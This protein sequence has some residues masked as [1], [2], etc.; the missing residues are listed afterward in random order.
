MRKVKLS[1]VLF[2]QEGPGVRN[3]QFTDSG[4][5]LLN[6]G[7]INN[8]EID[9]STTKIHISRDEAYGKYKHFLAE[10]GDLVIASSGIIVSNFHNKIAF[11]KK[12]HLPLCMNTSTIRFRALDDKELDINFF[13]FFLQTIFFKKQL[14]RLITGSAQLNFGPSHLKQIELPLPDIRI[15]KDIA[16]Q[17]N[18]AEGLYRTD[19]QLSIKYLEL[20]QSTYSYFFGDVKINR[21][22]YG[23][24][25]MCDIAEVAS[26]VAKN[27]SAYQHDFIEVPYMRVANVQDGYISLEEIKTIKVSTS[28]YQRYLLQKNDILLTEGGDPDKL[29]RGAVWHGRIDPCIHQNHIFRVRPNANIINSVYLSYHIGSSYG[30]KY[31]LKAAKQTTG[32]ASIN[33]TQLKNFEVIVPP[34]SLQNQFAEIITNIEE[35]KALVKLQQ[36]KSEMLFK[37]LL[38]QAFEG[39]L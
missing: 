26:G 37:S 10:E 18:V 19:I 8:G 33:M 21:K 36:Q 22:K 16:T 5:K 39:I 32:I 7:N 3:V 17:L 2:F 1:E 25:K 38:Q 14:S 28:D 11:I 31:F 6:V 13:R 9:L 30:K 34:L 35:Q 24:K 12:E 20:L 23:A 27:T 29:G 4:I 15:Q